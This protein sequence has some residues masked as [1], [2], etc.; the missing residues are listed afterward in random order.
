VF[1]HYLERGADTTVVFVG[2]MY[3]DD[4]EPVPEGPFYF[5]LTQLL[6]VWEP[7]N[8]QALLESINRKQRSLWDQAIQTI[9]SIWPLGGSS[10]P[11]IETEKLRKVHFFVYRVVNRDGLLVPK[12]VNGVDVTE[13]GLLREP[14]AGMAIWQMSI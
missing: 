13:G 10:T 6:D 2:Y 7:Q 12:G 11:R 9:S 5:D 14:E 1:E 8:K 4:A 3:P